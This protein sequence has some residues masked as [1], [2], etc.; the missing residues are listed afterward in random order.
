[1]KF[2]ENE[3]NSNLR[4]AVLFSKNDSSSVV[5]KSAQFNTP[6]RL[7]TPKTVFSS[8]KKSMP[9]NPSKLNITADEEQIWKPAVIAD[10]RASPRK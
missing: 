5:N 4:K 6:K 7:S 2:F 10:E 3:I 1:M 8:R 9:V